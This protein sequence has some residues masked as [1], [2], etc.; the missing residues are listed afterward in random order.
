MKAF[1]KLLVI[2][3]NL[4]LRVIRTCHIENAKQNSL[5][6]QNEPLQSFMISWR[7]TLPFGPHYFKMVPVKPVELFQCAAAFDMRT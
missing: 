6:A 5:R 2:K 3:F 7:H 1:L 4:I